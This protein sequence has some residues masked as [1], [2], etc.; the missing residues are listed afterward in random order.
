MAR[1]SGKATVSA[2]VAAAMVAAAGCTSSETSKVRAAGVAETSEA[3]SVQAD[4]VRCREATKTACYTADQ[5][6]TA[7]GID[8]LARKGITGKGR[9]IAII[10]PI[11]APNA[12]K[13]LETFSKKTGL[14]EADLKIVNH[15]P[16]SGTAAPFDWSDDIMANSAREVT[17]DLQAA[18]AMAPDARLVLHQMGADPDDVDDQIS[19]DALVQLIEVLGDITDNKAD[20]VSLSLGFPEVGPNVKGYDRLY[21][22][23]TELFREMNK[24][25][26]TVVASSGDSGVYDPNASGGDTK[27]R[28]VDWPS[29]DPNVTA[30]GGTRLSLDDNGN[31]TA[32]DTVWNDSVGAPGG[33]RSAVFGRPDYQAEGL[34][35]DAAQ[36]RR[37]VPDVSLS[38]SASA[39][40]MIYITTDKG[41]SWEPLGGT[42]LAAPLFAGIVALAA[43]ET[44]TGLGHVN[45]RLYSMAPAPRTGERAGVIDITSG[46]NGEGGFPAGEGYD[47]ASGLGTVDAARLVPALAQKS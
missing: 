13:D 4:R 8:E 16:D 34:V 19:P 35:A 5:L 42:S 23:V 30:V 1:H 18:H 17:M 9:T 26:I 2:L 11:G 40:T 39:S 28:T 37:A 22:Q 38:A 10:D 43:Q 21:K 41:G 15:K 45:P 33:G 25:G 7:Y 32:P 24:E 29:S 46:T 3:G 27:V 6:R 36:G 31:R 44:G 12:A 14:P 47:L 20:V